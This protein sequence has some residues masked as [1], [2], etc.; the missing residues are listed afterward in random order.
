MGRLF[1]GLNKKAEMKHTPVSWIQ[2]KG[3]S[4]NEKDKGRAKDEPVVQLL[5]CAY[6]YGP[7]ISWGSPPITVDVSAMTYPSELTHIPKNR[8]IA[9]ASVPSI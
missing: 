6:L 3:P 9:C 1:S 8:S 2:L 4:V 7:I 5:L